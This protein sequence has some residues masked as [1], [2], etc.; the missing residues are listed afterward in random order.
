MSSTNGDQS[1]GFGRESPVMF[2]ESSNA[3]VIRISGSPAIRAAVEALKQGGSAVDAAMIAALAQTALAAGCWDSY[4]GIMSMVDYDAQTGNVHSMKAPYNTVQEE[5]DPLSIPCQGIPSGRTALV[6]GF[7]T[8]VQAAHD[9]FGTLRSAELFVPANE[10][11][12]REFVVDLVI[13]KCLQSQKD[14]MISL[15]AGRKIFTDDQL[16]LDKKDD[17]FNQPRL[18]ETCCDLRR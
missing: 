17:L 11:A 5:K 10:F 13:D 18:M 8:G 1:R 3:I 12:E 14:V 16:E 7:M 2:A 6:P 9:R 15:P 4:A